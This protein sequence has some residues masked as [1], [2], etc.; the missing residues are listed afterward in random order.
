MSPISNG[1]RN[2]LQ[3]LDLQIEAAEKLFA[4]LPGSRSDACLVNLPLDLSEGMAAA[5]LKEKRLGLEDGKIGVCEFSAL[6]HRVSFKPLSEFRI[7]ERVKLA[8]F[9]P[10][11]IEQAKVLEAEVLESVDEVADAIQQAVAEASDAT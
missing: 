2:S 1:L 11:L 8:K 4:G 3:N 7:A 10:K 6:G 9:I 5:V